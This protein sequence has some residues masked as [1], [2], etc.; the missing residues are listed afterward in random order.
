MKHTYPSLILSTV[1]SLAFVVPQ[2]QDHILQRPKLNGPADLAQWDLDGSGSWRVQNG[3]LVLEVAGKPEGPI[4][5]PAALAIL[6]TAPLRRV[7][8]QVQVRSTAPLD[9]PRRDLD[10]IFGYESP[11]RFYY[12]HLSAITDS[13]HNG[14]FLVADADRRRIDAG[15]GQPQL[16][17]QNWHSVRLERNGGSGVIQVFVD[18]S[19]APV[20]TASD[21]TLRAGR[22]GVGS[23][24]DTGEFRRM[25]VSGS[26]K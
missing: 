19:K 11:K 7:T 13:V 20:L 23:F 21:T 2:A 15:T 24:D 16:K 25:S 4:R 9:V 17:D 18:G 12:V 1:L 14:I 5:R 26:I 8:M 22:V 3:S 10:L 6:K